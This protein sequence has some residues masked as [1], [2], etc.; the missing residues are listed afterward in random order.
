MLFD[1]HCHI[2]DS[3]YDTDRPDVLARAAEAGVGLMLC[4]A[5]GRMLTVIS[6]VHEYVK[7]GKTMN[8]LHISVSLKNRNP[9]WDEMCFVKEKL[10]GDEMP[11]VQFHPPRSEYV[12]EHEHCL[13]IWASEDF[14]ELWRRMGEEDY[15][16]TK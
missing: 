3:A 11:A 12:N 6:S 2:N 14:S 10:L 13:H 4:P 15:W 7:D 5:T 16:R 8:L 9:N 1:T